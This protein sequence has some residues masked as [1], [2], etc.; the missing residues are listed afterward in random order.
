[1][2]KPYATRK[3]CNCS[4]SYILLF[5]LL[6]SSLIVSAQTVYFVK[7]GATGDG[8]TWANASG[9]LQTMV[10]NAQ[11]S[12]QVWIAMG[13][14]SNNGL[15]FTF[16]EGVNVY[17]GFT[18]TETS[19]EQRN[20]L[21]NETILDGNNNVLVLQQKKAF[22]I[23]TIWDGFTI[24]H[25]AGLNEEGGGGVLLL[26]N[27]TVSNCTI[28]ENTAVNFG[29]GVYTREGSRIYNC[30]ISNNYALNGGGVFCANGGTVVGCTITGNEGTYGGG[31]VSYGG[32]EVINCLISN[33]TGTN[34]GGVYHAGGG[35]ITNSVIASNH[36]ST[37]GGGIWTAFGEYGAGPGLISNCIVWNNSSDGTAQQVSFEQVNTFAIVNYNNCAIQ[38]ISSINWQNI[39]NN[40]N[41]N[42]SSDNSNQDGPNFTNPGTGDFSLTALSP[43]INKGDNSYIL[44]YPVDIKNNARIQAGQVDMGCIESGFG[45]Q[46]VSFEKYYVSPEGDDQNDGSSW[47]SAKRTIQEAINVA[48]KSILSGQQK[49][50]WVEQGMYTLN[51]AIEF[52]QGI[53][54]YGG[55]AGNETLLEQRDWV[56]HIT[57]ID[58]NAGSDIR[59]VIV[60]TIDFSSLTSF[61]GFILTNGSVPGK[62]GAAIIRSNGVLTHCTVS[63]NFAGWYGGGIYLMRGSR[64]ENSTI[65]ANNSDTGG[66]VYLNMGGEVAN[67]FII[68]NTAWSGGGAFLNEKGVLSNNLIQGN[69]TSYAGAGVSA[70]LGG[71]IIN[72]TI[73]GNSG[74]QIGGGVNC[75][76]QD[77]WGGDPVIISN[78]II[79]NNLADADQ[80]VSTN[81][82]Q[83]ISFMNNSIQNASQI[84][85]GS[86]VH[87]NTSDLDESNNSISGPNF[88]NPETND[89]TLTDKSPCVNAGN[90]DYVNEEYDLAGEIRIK[91]SVVDNG[92]YESPFTVDVKNPGLKANNS[93]HIYPNP[94]SDF[95]FVDIADCNSEYTIVLLNSNGQ[96]VYREMN[97]SNGND[98]NEINLKSFT[99][100]HYIVCL[101][102]E[103]SK[104]FTKLVIN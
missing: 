75:E 28:T 63:G 100:G 32:G 42:L 92:A 77:G 69:S 86:V 55:F 30:V 61:D 2:R 66:G 97:N 83:Y 60:Q 50:I 49:V 22:S 53:N 33:N 54:I 47:S 14:Y 35:T 101:E 43:C 8:T 6:L 67:C 79:W 24:T 40:D 12:D 72:C 74:A 3:Y 52:K 104:H 81:G 64:V 11:P 102:T 73:T 13:T 84:I 5:F 99:P 15:A 58:A 103:G 18:G 38:D 27:G 9:N 23:E 98:R 68:N 91:E 89:Y 10:N 59:R 29:G 56:N 26:K 1:M 21:L 94:A 39:S 25:G 7:Q 41:V 45:T 34:G 70:F 80:Q 78:C 76:N 36:A 96:V 20:W 48:A 19:L 90:N 88:T 95:L 44:Q 51:S 85:W 31:I 4:K 57:T 87:E 82:N 71:S 37:D 17:G 93:I 46:P 16:K 65:T 62:G